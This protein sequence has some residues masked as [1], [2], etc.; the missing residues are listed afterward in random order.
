MGALLATMW[1]RLACKHRLAGRTRRLVAANTAPGVHCARRWH[2]H[3]RWQSRWHKR[4][5]AQHNACTDQIATQNDRAASHLRVGAGVGRRVC[6]GIR[7]IVGLH[8]AFTGGGDGATESAN[9]LPRG[10]KLRREI[11][12]CKGWKICGRGRWAHRGAATQ[13]GRWHEMP[14][15][16]S[17][18]ASAR[19]QHRKPTRSIARFIWSTPNRNACRTLVKGG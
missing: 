16:P 3:F 17:N 9:L 19:Q 18:H 13:I 5:A 15:S 7:N 11:R 2:R 6:S 14:A 8:A 10:R 12:W 1:S 4:R